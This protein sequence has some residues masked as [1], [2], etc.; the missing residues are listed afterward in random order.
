MIHIS[1]ISGTI[2]T[3]KTVIIERNMTKDMRQHLT[4]RNERTLNVCQN[5]QTLR[6]RQLDCP[7]KGKPRATSAVEYTFIGNTIEQQFHLPVEELR[8]C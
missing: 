5:Q 6:D 7:R 4:L 1:P 8:L 2:T 3:A